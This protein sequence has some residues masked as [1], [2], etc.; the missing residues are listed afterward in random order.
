M[1]LLAETPTGIVPT[2]VNYPAPA[3]DA[4]A[5]QVAVVGMLR[6]IRGE[7]AS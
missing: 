6:A 3:D 4:Y 5:V 2:R 7:T 1:D